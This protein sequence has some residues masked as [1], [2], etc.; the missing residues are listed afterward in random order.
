MLEAA[1]LS[2]D[3]GELSAEGISSK[4]QV[5]RH[6]K[7]VR[8]KPDGESDSLGEQRKREDGPVYASTD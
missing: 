1:Q 4:V 2:V 3:G 5:L 8:Y 6:P 7:S